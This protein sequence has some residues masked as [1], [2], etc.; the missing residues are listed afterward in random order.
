MYVTRIGS[1]VKEAPGWGARVLVGK[2]GVT[3]LRHR[4]ALGDTLMLTPLA[5]ALKKHRPDIRISIATRSP[6]LFANNPH[7]EE[8]RDWHL[9]R[10]KGT[11]RLNYRL[12]QARHPHYVEEMWMD[13]WDFLTEKKIVSGARPELEGRHPELFLTPDEKKRGLELLGVKGKRTKPILA[14]ISGGKLKPTHNREW[15]YANYVALAEAF[16]PHADLVQVSGEK[17]IV[18]PSTGKPVK[19]IKAEIRDLAGALS[20][21]DAFVTQEGGLM[22]V[23]R[24]VNTPSIVIFGGTLLP[25]HSGYD[26]MTNLFNK[27]E[28]SP[29]RALRHNCMHLKCMVPITPKLVAEHVLKLMAERGFFLPASIAASAGEKWTPPEFVDLKLLEQELA[30]K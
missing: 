16:A 25:E 9:F 21:C 30:K 22:H 8:V 4:E 27:P 11:V 19:T 10:D 7:F 24:A 17:P 20:E 28:C 12:E 15:G 23:A 1:L 2:N 29:C 18:L 13:L 5:R 14:L 26:R 6:E 3:F